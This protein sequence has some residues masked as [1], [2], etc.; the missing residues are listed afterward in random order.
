MK[1]GTFV[2]SPRQLQRL[3]NR[4]GRPLRSVG[5][6]IENGGERIYGRVADVGYGKTM[7]VL[8]NGET[9]MVAEKALAVASTGTTVAG[10]GLKVGA[11]LAPR[12]F[13]IAGLKTASHLIPYLGWGLAIVGGTK[14]AVK[15]AYR[16]SKHGWEP[17]A[18]PRDLLKVSAGIIGIED[19]FDWYPR[20]ERQ[21]M[22]SNPMRRPS[23]S[24]RAHVL[25]DATSLTL[26]LTDEGRPQG[27]LHLYSTKGQ[28]AF[29]TAAAAEKGYGPL[30]YDLGAILSGWSIFPSK[31][32]SPS[33]K[34]FWSRQK[35]PFEPM[36][37]S[38]FRMKYGRHP[39]DLVDEN[40][41]HVLAAEYWAGKY[42][43]QFRTNPAR[44]PVTLY[45]PRMGLFVDVPGYDPIMLASVATVRS[46]YIEN[47]L[48]R[49]KR[50]PPPPPLRFRNGKPTDYTLGVLE[51]YVRSILSDAGADIRPLERVNRRKNPAPVAYVGAILDR[52]EQLLNWWSTNIGPL[53]DKKFAHHMTIQ[54]KPKSLDGYEVGSSVS[55]RVVGFAQNEHVQAVVV[56]AVGAT[57]SNAVPH[58]TVATDGSPPV[59]SND[60]LQQGYVSVR[61]P[62]LSARVGFNQAGKDVF[63]A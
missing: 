33:A 20:A 25:S 19:L 6:Y 52:P 13:A 2:R 59:L 23:A 16:H 55:L 44:T 58:I 46:L 49:R 29:P 17:K 34:A 42:L 21:G 43:G 4:V 40:F 39:D 61:G 26:L 47:K 32:R 22:K 36:R 28:T 31:E 24:L 51:V 38:E 30:L 63:S 10:V 57:S 35:G 48:L 41:Q 15:A 45:H 7:A 60:L 18:L 9:A 5:A 14:E 62:Y 8:A 1:S 3:A 37:A 56:E 11:K 50:F 54:F 27:Y 53:L 12:V